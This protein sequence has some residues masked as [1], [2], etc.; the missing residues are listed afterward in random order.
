M[1]DLGAEVGMR[2]QS[3]YSYFS[4]K[5]DLYDAMFADGNRAFIRVLSEPPLPDPAAAPDL[6]A[7]LAE[8]ARR[9]FD[10]CVQD[11]VRYQLLF[12]RTIP[13]FT[14]SPASYELA[15]Q[16]YELGFAGLRSVGIDDEGLDLASGVV[17]GLVAQQ[18][19]NQPGGDRWKRLVDR[20]VDMVLRE[21]APQLLLTRAS[22][23]PTTR[24]TR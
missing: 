6:P 10:F 24:G 17:S 18:L 7:A 4:S 12:Q 19:A 22:T 3:L 11:P 8:H 13:G 21:V 9:F 14:P 2:A 16:A 23:T 20:A 5:H 15:R 1:R